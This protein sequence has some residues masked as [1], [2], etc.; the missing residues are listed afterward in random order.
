[1]GSIALLLVYLWGVYNTSFFINQCCRVYDHITILSYGR[2]IRYRVPN[3]PLGHL[4]HI[5]GHITI[6]LPSH[7]IG[8]LVH[9]IPLSPL[10]H[11]NGRATIPLP[12]HLISY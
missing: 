7:F 6:L 9:S 8:Y 10:H 11:A 12:G 3:H 5:M 1:M 2:F 4:H